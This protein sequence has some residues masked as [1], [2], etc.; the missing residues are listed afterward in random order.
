MGGDAA[1]QS[2]GLIWQG[3]V[4]SH[5]IGLVYCTGMVAL[6]PSGDKTTVQLVYVDKVYAEHLFRE[7]IRE[8]HV[9]VLESRRPCTF[10]GMG[11][12]TRR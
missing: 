12:W 2:H 8:H 1:A 5:K 10:G 7:S 6:D 4:G 11:A 3:H 9:G